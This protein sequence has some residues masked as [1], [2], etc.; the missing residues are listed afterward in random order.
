MAETPFE[1]AIRH[2]QGIFSLMAEVAS[3]IA[4]SE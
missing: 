2:L 4:R 3:Y 1:L